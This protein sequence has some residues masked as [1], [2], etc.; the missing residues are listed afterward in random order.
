MMRLPSST[1]ITKAEAISCCDL[2]DVRWNPKADQSTRVSRLRRPQ[3]DGYVNGLE[4]LPIGS[5]RAKLREPPH[6]LYYGMVRT[7]LYIKHLLYLT[8][9]ILNELPVALQLDRNQTGRLKLERR[10]GPPNQFYRFDEVH[11]WK[12]RAEIL[13]PAFRKD[14]VLHWPVMACEFL[15]LA[16]NLDTFNDVPG[17]GIVL[18]LAHVVVGCPDNESVRSAEHCYHPQIPSLVRTGV[19][20]LRYTDFCETGLLQWQALA[21]LRARETLSHLTSHM[22]RVTARQHA[23]LAASKDTG[24]PSDCSNDLGNPACR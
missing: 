7:G 20:V 24:E 2:V 19:G 22:S 10:V 1:H 12:I 15:E 6:P 11:L 23:W 16:E 9:D 3:G 14:L 8:F 13:E 5:T 18:I 4:A 17:R 21:R